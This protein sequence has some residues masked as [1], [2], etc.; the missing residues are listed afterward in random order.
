MKKED[1]TII[2]IETYPDLNM[3]DTLPEPKIDSRLKD[4]VK[5][6]AKKVEAKQKQI[7]GMALNPLYGKIACIGYSTGGESECVIEGTEEQ[8]INTFFD[9]ISLG[10]AESPKIVT[11]NGISFDIPFI[12]K[13]AMILG[14]KPHISMSY[15]MK[16]YTTSPHCDLM[17]VWCNWYGMEALNTVAKALLNKEKAEFDVTTIKDLIK[18][19]EGRKEISSYCKKDVDITKEL[20]DK[21]AG[22]LF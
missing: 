15:W 5:I 3:V 19:P 18:T 20:F 14:I 4:P 8:I 22:I 9:I 17:Q 11:W 21:M 13:R 16:R 6:E 2:D 12:Y 7:D 1:Y 10:R